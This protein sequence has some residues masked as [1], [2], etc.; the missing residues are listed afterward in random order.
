MDPKAL[1]DFYRLTDNNDEDRG[2][3]VPDGGDRSY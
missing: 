2:L 3:P 1:T